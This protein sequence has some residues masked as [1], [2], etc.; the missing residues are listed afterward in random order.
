[1]GG[2]QNRSY[3]HPN[4]RLTREQ[5]Y[6]IKFTE[7]GPATEVAEKYGINYQSVY[8]IRWGKTWGWLKQTE[9]NHALP[10]GYTAE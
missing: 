1:M 6:A 5:A 4:A 8:S 9:K 2:P 3:P 10:V 7:K